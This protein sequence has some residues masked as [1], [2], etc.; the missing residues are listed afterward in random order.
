MNGRIWVESTL[1]VGSTFFFTAQLGVQADQTERR[2]APHQAGV[3]HA[4]DKDLERLV[5]GC[6]FCW[7]TTRTTT[8]S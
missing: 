1:G 4:P 3:A 7:P 8:A 6:A 2:A 5:A